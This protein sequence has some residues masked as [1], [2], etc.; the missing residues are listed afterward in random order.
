MRDLNDAISV[1][2]RGACKAYGAGVVALDGVDLDIGAGELLC[3]LGP[4]GSGKTTLLNAIAGLVP[5]D[6]GRVLFNGVDVS[7]ASPSKR[8]IGYV[9]QSHSLYPTMRVRNNIFFAL[10]ASGLSKAERWQRVVWA[11][12]LMHIDDLLDRRPKE[13]SGGESQRVA[14][15]R[16]IAK[17]PRLLLL[18]EPFSS[19]DIRLRLELRDTLR[20]V[21]RELGVTSIM[22]THDPDEALSIADRIA[23]VHGGRLEQTGT[24]K[25]LL[26]SPANIF[27]A[28]FFGRR[29]MNLLE[30]SC[31]GEG[32][33][34][35]IRPYDAAVSRVAPLPAGEAV[36]LGAEAPVLD[37]DGLVEGLEYFDGAAY[38]RIR[39]DVCGASVWTQI[40]SRESIGVGD[41]L[42]LGVSRAYAFSRE[43]GRLIKVISSPS[44]PITIEGEFHEHTK[45]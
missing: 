45:D 26:A 38:A 3:L 13:L 6:S 8:G 9:F 23:V 37:L 19:L 31:G 41:R 18:D 16:A 35:G 14:I 27:V 33:V 28:T 43:S 10:E 5:L 32:A 36:P 39:L 21:Q 12:S 22:V 34:I 25:D 29:P 30:G 4:S 17:H 40:G 15:A 24:P 42:R 44:T 7:A 2:V 11:A 1:S 20:S